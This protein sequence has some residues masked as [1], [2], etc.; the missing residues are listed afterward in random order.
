MLKPIF[1]LAIVSLLMI[2]DQASADIEFTG[3]LLD[4]PC[5]IDPISATQDVEFLNTT[6]QQFQSLPGR[7]PVENFSIKLTNC[8]SDSLY[9]VVRVTF[10][11]ESEPNLPGAL[12]VSGVNSGKLAIQLVDAASGSIINLDEVNNGG[13]GTAVNQQ[14]LVLNYSTYVQATPTALSKKTV[15]AGD[16]QGVVTFQ[17]SYH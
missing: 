9:K 2:T 14:A 8:R 16:Y 5:Q 4:R 1:S 11:G 17:V 6:V 10:A 12:K 7:S 13:P 3:N 15:Q